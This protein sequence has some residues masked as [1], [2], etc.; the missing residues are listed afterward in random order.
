[1]VESKTTEHDIESL[2]DDVKSL[3]EDFA[4]LVKH[5]QRDA[6]DAS[7][8]FAGVLSD[9]AQRLYGNVADKGRRSAK[10]LS[11]Q[12]EEQPLMSL[13]IAFAVGFLGGR[14]LSPR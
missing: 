4:A 9:E 10:A 8:D 7:T 12:V 3:K 1:M 11:A 6:R 14:F 5:V 2:L 13:A